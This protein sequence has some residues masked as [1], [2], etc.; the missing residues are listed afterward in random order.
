MDLGNNVSKNLRFDFCVTV[1]AVAVVVVQSL[2]C[3]LLF[4]TPRMQHTRLLHYLP[5]S[6]HIHVQ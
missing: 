1:Y 3:A 4:V 5:E 2:S 6:A